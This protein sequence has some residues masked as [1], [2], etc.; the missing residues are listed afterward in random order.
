MLQV[1]FLIITLF[2]FFTP[3]VFAGITLTSAG[4]GFQVPENS[5]ESFV[6][7]EYFNLRNAP[8]VPYVVIN[9]NYTTPSSGN[10]GDVL[11]ITNQLTGKQF[12]FDSHCSTRK[13]PPVNLNN[14]VDSDVFNSGGDQILRFTYI[15]KC[16]NSKYVD[17]MFLLFIGSES[18]GSFLPIM[19]D[20]NYDPDAPQKV[21]TDYKQTDPKWADA[22]LGNS[23]DCGTLYSYGCAVSAVAD[24]LYFYG[25]TQLVDSQLHPGTLNDWLSN[26]DGFTGCSIVWSKVAAV[27]KLGAPI[28]LFR[29]SS[30]DWSSGKDAIDT[31]LIQGG[32][33][34]L[35]INTKYGTHFLAASAKLPDVNGQPDY[36]L[37]DPAL[38]PFAVN[39]PGNSG[40][41]LSEV[42]GGFSNVF[43]TVIYRS[44]TTPEKTLTVRAHSPV[45]L[46]ITDPA[47][48]QT[49]Y[50]P[51]TQTIIR[52]IALS[53]YGIEP[54]IAPTDG[55]SPAVG[56]T[57]YFQ[58]ITPQE[59]NYKLDVIGI[60]NGNYTLD[61]STTDEK[62]NTA[63]KVL[64]GIAQ[65]AIT[66]SYD[67][68]VTND[69]S[70]APFTRREV[71][72]DILQS[73]IKRMYTLG[74]INN[75]AIYATLQAAV[76]VAEKTSQVNK[77]PL[78]NKLAIVALKA[79]QLELNKLRGKSIS[80]DAF[81]I[82]NDDADVLIRELG[83]AGYPK[84]T[85]G[86][87]GGS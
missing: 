75:K 61:I 71:T 69:A 80:E 59:G 66:E 42:Y 23:S 73:D 2:I 33:P 26:N 5:Q 81:Q 41:S 9:G 15:N 72:F 16:P 11:E 22:H 21:L 77:Q 70:L 44:D 76:Q 34:I 1:F 60:G 8:R 82:L 58:Q 52:N 87:G 51:A 24:V 85:P 54:G 38:Y 17:P 12:V 28:I 79:F 86:S 19:V 27:V 74:K 56:E 48:N 68:T 20:T 83:G 14:L 84:P 13:L 25:K 32:I 45:Q 6:R 53:S 55:S 63:T 39:N 67:I 37:I 10:V 65:K 62:G 49:G 30:T 64:K 50:N 36:K 29:N 43:E 35:G 3:K 40:K 18:I 7:I 78:G 47:G 57:K 4:G 31:A 46:L